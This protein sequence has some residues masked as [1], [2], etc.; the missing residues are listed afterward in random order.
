MVEESENPGSGPRMGESDFLAERRARRAT[1]TGEAA[2][3]R[4]AEAAEATVKTLES[5]VSSL[6]ARLQEAEEEQ[7][8][9]AALLEAER[10]H[11]AER[12]SELRRVK[13]REYAEQ[14]LRVEAEGRLSGLEREDRERLGRDETAGAAGD[15]ELTE[16]SRRIDGLQRQLAEAEHSAASERAALRRAEGEL[17]TRVAGL[18]RRA[19]ELQRGLVSERSARERAERELAGIREG[20]RRMEGLLGEIRALISRLGS[21]IGALREKPAP[22]PPASAPNPL[23]APLGAVGAGTEPSAVARQRGEE[24]AEALAAAVERLRARA[25]SAPPLPEDP[26]EHV[27]EAPVP[28]PSAPP[29]APLPPTV[30]SGAPEAEQPSVAVADTEQAKGAARPENASEPAAETPAAQAVETVREPIAATP[31]R[32]ANKH[33]QSL[34]SRIRNRRKERR[35]R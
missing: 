4:R 33:S 7:R 31:K 8:R 19:E 30:S 14:Q 13:Q 28:D 12:E 15:R 26:G 25:L 21:V 2:L 10:A 35:G 16:L 17:A 18:E 27:A 20:H 24:M 3:L 23:A 6:Q 11:A 9:A 29:R 22:P 5:H 1:E 34:I 32:P